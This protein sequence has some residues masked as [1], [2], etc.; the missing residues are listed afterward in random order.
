MMPVGIIDATDDV[1][2]D[3]AEPYFDPYAWLGPLQTPPTRKL[4]SG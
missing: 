1:G 3:L 4:V 2:L